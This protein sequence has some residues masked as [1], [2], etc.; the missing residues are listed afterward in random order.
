VAI[1]WVMLGREQE[2][3]DWIES[4]AAVYEEREIFAYNCAC[5][6][7]RALEQVLKSPASAERDAAAERY[8]DR[9]LRWLRRSVERG[10]DQP[11]LMK[12]DAD[13]AALRDSPEF[14]EL[15]NRVATA[16]D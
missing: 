12:T 8:R 3:F 14:D 6:Y 1:S 10:F 2:A 5:V 7:G 15:L 13:L 11:G 4:A 16:M 9:G